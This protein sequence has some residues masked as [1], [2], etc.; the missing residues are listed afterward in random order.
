MSA[1]W[2]SSKEGNGWFCGKNDF[3]F[4]QWK[5]YS[6]DWSPSKILKHYM[7]IPRE[8]S[9]QNNAKIDEKCPG[10]S[11][12]FYFTRTRHVSTGVLLFWQKISNYVWIT[13]H[14]LTHLTIYLGEQKFLTDDDWCQFQK[15]RQFWLISRHRDFESPNI[16]I[17][18]I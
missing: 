2:L 9:E 11:K 13:Y 4:L 15:T 10:L 12:K 6:F 18:L 7:R 16:W 1:H 8:F 5:S 17:A 14:L 3:H